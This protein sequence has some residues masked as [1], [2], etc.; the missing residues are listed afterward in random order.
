MH[1]VYFFFF[2]LF[3]NRMGAVCFLFGFPRWEGFHSVL[4][5]AGWL[6]HGIRVTQLPGAASRI[7]PFHAHDDTVVLHA[8]MLCF[9]TL[10]LS[11]LRTRHV[12]VFAFWPLIFPSTLRGRITTPFHLPRWG[13][14]LGGSHTSLRPW[15]ISA[16]DGTLLHRREKTDTLIRVTTSTRYWDIFCLDFGN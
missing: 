16:F 8:L 14:A 5:W 12:S 6:D 1:G 10:L 4:G 7:K 2:S 11:I 15:P 13:R 3:F 9:W